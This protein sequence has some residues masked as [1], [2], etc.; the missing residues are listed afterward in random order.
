LDIKKLNSKLQA[1]VSGRPASSEDSRQDGE[2]LSSKQRATSYFEF[3][4]T[5]FMYLPVALQ[6]L[7]L[8]VK[9]RSL[10]LPLLANPRIALAGMVGASKHELMSQAHGRCAAAILPWVHVLVT[11]EDSAFQSRKCIDS[12]GKRG[13]ALPFVCKPDMGCRGSGVKLIHTLEQLAEVI[14]QY[15]VGSA[16]ICQK[17][18]SFEPEVGIFY[19][20]SPDCE[21]GEVVSLTIKQ[22]PSV[23]GDGVHTLEQLVAQDDRAKNLLSLYRDRNAADW[24]R[25]LAE[26]ERHRLLFSASHCRGAVFSDAREHITPELV[27]AVNEIMA[28]LPEFYYGRMDVKFS[29]LDNLKCGKNLQI[30]E[31]N[32]ASSESIHI[33]DKNA[34]LVDAIKTLLWQYRTL[35]HLGAH[36]R[37]TG[38]NPPGLKVLIKSWLRERELTRHYPAT[39]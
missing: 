7:G 17:L 11:E 23:I 16:L 39:D 9:H 31:I 29:D 12:A 2:R 14:A 15:P 6:W 13:I 10:T 36:Q 38:L 35:F 3:W 18:A 27:S 30:I 1:A 26:G 5:W 37:N 22:T 32:G 4:P 21:I 28:D 24:S 20:R 8:S 19:V 34:R 25:V 33:W